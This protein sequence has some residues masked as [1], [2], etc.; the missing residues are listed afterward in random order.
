[1]FDGLLE[2]APRCDACGATFEGAEVG[3]GATV[4]ALFIVGF[5]AITLFLLV[6]VA[7]RGLPWW[8]HMIIQVP[9]IFGASILCLRPLK[10]LLF[11]L[12]FQHDAQ[13]GQ[14]D[15]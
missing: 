10:G 15:E 3:D 1:M 5:L 12:Q 6:A 13:Q 7:F 2:I 4:F 8:G 14:L 11:A 9:F